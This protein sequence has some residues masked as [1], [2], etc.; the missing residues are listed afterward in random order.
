MTKIFSLIRWLWGI[1][2]LRFMF[3]G[4]ISFLLC[5]AIYYPVTLL[6]QSKITI[7]DE[8]FY[9]PAILISNPIVIVAS[10]YMNKKWT[11]QDSKTRSYS[12]A[13][14]ELMG[15][16]TIFLDMAV[17][18]VLVHFAHI[19]YLLGMVLTALIMFLIRY[20]ISNRWI[21]HVKKP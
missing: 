17:L 6:I 19:Y 11:Y 7:L 3:F 2:I 20:T 10:Y 5:F 13:R 16:S 1:R 18:F 15:M 8:V 14:Y 9:L 12:L 21:W 4:G